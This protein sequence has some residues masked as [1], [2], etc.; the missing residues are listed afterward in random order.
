[1]L[2]VL[3]VLA[4]L[5]AILIPA[6]GSVRSHALLAECSSNQRQI[7]LALKLYANDNKG[8]YP[9]STHSTGP[10]RRDR[11]WI[12]ALNQYFTNK[13]DEIRVCPVDP[14]ERQKQVLDRGATSYVLN[15]LVFDD[16]QYHV[17]HWIPEPSRTLLLFILS[18]DRPPSLTN[19]HI[20]GGEWTN[21]YAALNDIEPD[22][23][24]SGKRSADRTKGS[25]PYLFAD[26]HVEVIE[27]A[28]F[29]SR[30]DRGE[31]PA[32]VPF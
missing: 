22:R 23:H 27:A 3:A 24:R 11:S 8:I 31:N 6:V 29:K 28:D 2:L 16:P 5:A 12:F 32:E 15:D 21:W 14:P 1:M 20:H 17:Q 10:F 18:E 7:G 9:P 26:G 4:T 19:D 25:A 30:F 13:I